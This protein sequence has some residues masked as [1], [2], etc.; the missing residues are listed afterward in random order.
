MNLLEQLK[1]ALQG[2][3]GQVESSKVV[4]TCV[5]DICR[6]AAAQFSS[7]ESRLKL[8]GLASW[9]DLKTRDEELQMEVAVYA[10]TSR[11]RVGW[12]EREARRMIA[13]QLLRKNLRFRIE[14]LAPILVAI[15]KEPYLDYGIP[16]GS[17]LG[18]VERFCAGRPPQGK[19]KH[20]LE[21][22]KLKVECLGRRHMTQFLSKA[23]SRIDAILEP[24]QVKTVQFPTGEWSDRLAPWMEKLTDKK[25]EAWAGLFVF[26]VTAGDKSKPTKK[27]LTGVKPMISGIGRPAVTR[28]ISQWLAETTPDPRETDLSLDVLKGLIW[29]SVH[30]D[31]DT[32]APAIGRFAETCFRKVP[33][34]GPRSIKLGNACVAT[35]S[36]MRGCDAAVA[37]L[38]RLR[39]RIKYGSVREL[40]DRRLADMAKTAGVSITD[41][42]ESALPDFGFESDGRQV[43]ELGDTIATITLEFDGPALSWQG[44]D[45]KPRKAPPA[46]VKHDFSDELKALKQRVKDIDVA[47]SVQ[48]TR[49]E[50]SWVEERAWPLDLWR[51][52]YPDH[53][54][55]S[56]ICKGLI[57]R[58][59]DNGK[60]TD[61]MPSAGKFVTVD[62]K[63]VSPDPDT[64]VRLWH[65]LDTD[66]DRVLAW[67]RCIMQAEL[68]QPIKQA[69]REVYVLTDAERATDIYSNRFAAHILRQHQFRALCQARGWRYEFQGGWDSHNIPSRR[70]PHHKLTVE[71][72]VD[73]VEDQDMSEAYIPLHIATDQVRFISDDREQI[74]LEHIPPILFSELMR[75]VDLFVA[76]TSVANDPDWT[77]G[78]PD[79]RYGTYWREYAFGDLSQ[80]ASTRRDLMAEIVPKLAIAD[81]LNVTDRFLEVQGKLCAYRIHLGSSNIQIMP[82]K[83]YLCIVRGRSSKNQNGVKLPFTGDNLLSIIL[84]KAFMLVS[85]DKITDKT[86]LSQ[87][88]R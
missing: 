36:A 52:R 33:D 80:T 18:A 60:L 64:T 9:E 83:Q 76:V 39:T 14:H 16:L 5:S 58:L 61:V 50:A 79:G 85:D 70:L 45:G 2:F 22:L 75:D 40:I 47:W 68:T 57:W 19:L 87:L 31:Q 13:S 59:D 67:R 41:L 26:A 54:L 71:Y 34:Y 86:I 37:E 43:I 44:A 74:S 55:R 46:A 62:G 10:A 32:I 69:H 53:P 49:I 11:V 72:S 78:G 73:P 25:R 88:E 23:R 48:V 21:T 27:W 30:L 17:V 51:A 38:V 81:R 28:Q 84:S 35:L 63:T 56:Q 20:L 24:D 77:D 1:N 8:S 15:A 7:Y 42:E 66:P 65:P 82:S 12:R 29:A 4:K 3:D 6:E